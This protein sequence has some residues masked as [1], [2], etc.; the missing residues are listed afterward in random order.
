MADTARL[1]QLE[2]F[3][4]CTPKELRRL[5]GLLDESTVAAG[6][7]LTAEGDLGS[8]AF[9]LL[10]GTAEARHGERV[11]ATLGPGDLVG[12]MALLDRAGARSATV[13]TTT[14][15]EVL[16]MDPRAFETVMSQFPSVARNVA[17]TLA[18]RL[19]D[20]S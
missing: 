18:K 20:A 14:P 19:R 4:S 6:T 15:A 12:E 8:Q 2:L 3:A 10:S 9:V 1:Q 17:T 5:A 16:V 13:V 7:V 11:V